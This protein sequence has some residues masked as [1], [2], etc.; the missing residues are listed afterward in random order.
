M[1]AKKKAKEHMVKEAGGHTGS[2]LRQVILGGQ[3]GLVNVLG[4]ILGVAAAT[5][6][7]RIVIIAGL[8]A[9]MAESI[10]MAA[11]AYTSS[12]AEK[13]YYYKQLGQEKKEIE[14]VPD[15]EREEIRLIYY[16]KGFRGKQ[17]D[18]IVKKITSDRKV[19]LDIMMSEE[20]GL[21]ESKLKNPV[22]EGVVVGVSA[23]IGSLIPL[24][25][26]FFFPVAAAAVWGLAVSVVS[27][28]IFG[29]IKSKLTAGH[30]ARSGMEM[31]VVGTVAAILG[32]L[33]GV[34]L[35]G[36]YY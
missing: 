17:L 31:A 27:L 35:G 7:T 24:A 12:K 21:T 8:A 34:F 26:F 14:E 33:I 20:L 15:I 36:V 18:Q 29:A 28:F 11:V 30:W 19:W 25:P 22:M 10:S 2:L 32:Y 5:N 23:V 9:T 1:N 4:L 13:E 3:D 16:K 6:D